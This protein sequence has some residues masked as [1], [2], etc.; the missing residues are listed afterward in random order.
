[1]SINKESTSNDTNVNDK[2]ISVDRIASTQLSLSVNK[3]AKLPTE[4]VSRNNSQLSI[5]TREQL[6]REQYQMSRARKLVMAYSRP[7]VC[8]HCY[9][10]KKRT[11]NPYPKDLSE[12]T[13]NQ[14]DHMDV[15][16]I[17]VLSYVI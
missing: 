1:M 12:Y 16:L 5:K 10:F 2:E 9:I 7:T 3:S 14:H 15:T 11:I 13:I 6:I 17:S 8:S 4:R